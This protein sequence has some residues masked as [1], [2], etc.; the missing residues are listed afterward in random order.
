MHFSISVPRLGVSLGQLSIGCSLTKNSR[1]LG[2]AAS[3]PS[4]GPELRRQR[5]DLWESL[6]KR[7][8]SWHAA[9]PSSSDTFDGS[10]NVRYSDPSLISGKN[11]LPRFCRM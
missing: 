7:S 4:S 1:L 9:A 6:Q 10:V 8:Q 2:R 11:S 5:L 3:V